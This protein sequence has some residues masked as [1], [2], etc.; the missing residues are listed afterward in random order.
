ML[1]EPLV[2]LPSCTEV[3][4]TAGVRGAPEVLV[5]EKAVLALPAEAVT[6]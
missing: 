5:S 6:V 1:Y 4:V 2:E 3:G